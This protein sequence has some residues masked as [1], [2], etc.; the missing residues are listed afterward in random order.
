MV[1]SSSTIEM[2]SDEILTKFIDEYFK[3]ML[4][5]PRV[6]NRYLSHDVSALKANY[7]AYVVSLFQNNSAEYTGRSLNQA[8]SGLGI[9]KEEFEV[10]LNYIQDAAADAGFSYSEKQVIVA[11]LTSIKDEVV[12][13]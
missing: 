2:P 9:T 12:G 10:A 13:N 1:E 8:H 6:R 4:E 7:K 11:K 5:D 3:H